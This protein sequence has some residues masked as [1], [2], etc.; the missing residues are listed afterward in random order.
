MPR[1]YTLRYEPVL[2]ID[3]GNGTCCC[4]NDRDTHTLVFPSVI[5]QVEDVR[6]DGSGSQG[7]VIHVQPMRTDSGARVRKSWAVGETA[8]L[9][10]GLQ[11]R[12]TSAARIGAEYQLVLILAAT[13]RALAELVDSQATSIKASVAWL[14]N[15]P[16][17]KGPT[18]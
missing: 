13:V 1:S 16:P 17:N 12:I 4:V 18:I 8:T 11:T 6:L 10:P 15:T 9:L 5:Q 3:A 2:A 14:L 7:F